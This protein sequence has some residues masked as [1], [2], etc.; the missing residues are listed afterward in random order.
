MKILIAGLLSVAFIWYT[1]TPPA[2]TNQTQSTKVQTVQAVAPEKV[3]AVLAA[4]PT[5]PQPVVKLEIQ[6]QGCDSYRSL[7]SQYDWNVN[8]A[9]A[10]CKAES[11][12]RTN[13]VSATHDFGLMQISH[14]H[15]D[16]VNGQLTRLFDPSTNIRIAY[17]L[18]S[19]NGWQPWS[20]Y[21]NHTYLRFM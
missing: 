12:G 4:A 2:L 21:K 13:V 15:K 18:Y 20:A 6:P 1:Q 14:V 10:I 3:T 9:I 5:E 11:G 19:A 17:S 16:M 7:F 8:T